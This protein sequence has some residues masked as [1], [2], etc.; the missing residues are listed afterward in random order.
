M[1]A[2]VGLF[3]P[4]LALSIELTDAAPDR[5]ERQRSWVRGET[6]RPG[7]PDVATVEARLAAKGLTEGNPVFIRIFKAESE[8]AQIEDAARG[9]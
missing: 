6:P 2:L 4:A 1:A 8:L 3:S 9:G 5:V 7:A